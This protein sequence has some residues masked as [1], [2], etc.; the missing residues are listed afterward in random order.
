MGPQ[1]LFPTNASLRPVDPLFTEAVASLANEEA[2]FMAHLVVPPWGAGR[3]E[4]TGT[5]MRGGTADN[6]SYGGINTSILP[7]GKPVRPIGIQPTAVTFSTRDRAL[8]TV[9]DVRAQ[10]IS[11]WD[12]ETQQV[13]ADY[14]KMLIEDELELATSLG[15]SGNWNAGSF[16]IAAGD[17]WNLAGSD[18]VA[19]FLRADQLLRA[20]GRRANTVVISGDGA[21]ALRNNAKLTSFGA[22]VV[23]NNV[24]GDD[25]IKALVSICTG[26][27]PERVF[28]ADAVSNTA[29]QG[30]TAVLAQAYSGFAWVGVVESGPRTIAVQR[31]QIQTAASALLRLESYALNV[32]EYEEPQSGMLGARV[33]KFGKSDALLPLNS[34]LGVYIGTVV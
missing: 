18:P 34:E 27:P 14:V 23:D 9:I 10:Q 24:Y 17:R 13:A 3:I 33:Y 32:M 11:Q 4:K 21:A 31:N 16:S 28:L 22:T 26:A 30:L 29:G 20:T 25:R 5:I 7:G 1:Q 19:D 6:F 8:E 2:N 12:F 15:T